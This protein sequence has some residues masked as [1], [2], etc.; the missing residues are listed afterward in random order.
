MLGAECV[1]HDEEDLRVKEN[2]NTSLR[3]KLFG[4]PQ[5]KSPTVSEYLVLSMCVSVCVLS[6]YMYSTRY[7]YM[8]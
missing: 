4:Q 2:G 6:L 7:G 5:R 3:R 8:V 1:Y